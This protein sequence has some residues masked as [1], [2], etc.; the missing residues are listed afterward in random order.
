M[1][2]EGALIQMVNHGL[3]TGALFLLVG[4]L[5]ERRHTK[6]FDDFGGLA[7]VIPCFS[8][9]LV[10]S[11]L[12]SVGLPALNG[13]V[14]EF[15]ILVGS[16]KAGLRLAVVVATSGVILA[17]VYLLHMLSETIWGPLEREE[18]RKILDLSAR[19]IAVL[20]PLAILMLAIG[21]APERFLA[22]S[23]PALREVATEYHER[24]AVPPPATVLL[25]NHVV[26]VEASEDEETSR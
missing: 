1:A 19:E 20:T 18:N 14:G 5:Y 2:W 15:L 4:M 6:R 7:K 3:S 11:A 8:F 16:F 25:R 13:F 23:R 22:P 17:A 26:L 21:L 24:L 10:F 9:F 12:A